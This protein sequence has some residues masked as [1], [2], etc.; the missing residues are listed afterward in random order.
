MPARVPCP[1]G[2]ALAVVAILA[3]GCGGATGH[4]R[5]RAIASP[6]RI[7][8][9]FAVLRSRRTSD[10]GL[11]ASALHALASSR[12]PYFAASSYRGARRVLASPPAWL[13][14]A[15]GGDLCLVHII[16]PLLSSFHGELLAPTPTFTCGSPAQA[17]Q[18]RLLDVQSLSTTATARAPALVLGVLPDGIGSVTIGSRD[19]PDVTAPVLRNAFAAKI[20]APAW[21]RYTEGAR[22]RTTSLRPFVGP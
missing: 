22:V 4:V 12:R 1:L 21:L 16:Y 11:P 7:P 8:R 18:G 5:G 9:G 15:N 2:P 10:D 19:G 13:L 3:T 17:R 20:R 14:S 6:E